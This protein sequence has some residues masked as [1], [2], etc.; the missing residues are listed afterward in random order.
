MDPSKDCDKRM[1]IIINRISDM[2]NTFVSL[3]VHINEVLLY[4][5]SRAGT[6]ENLLHEKI[7]PTMD[8]CAITIAIV[9][10]CPP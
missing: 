1:L 10:E 5:R 9:R 3:A 7:P 4:H 6:P 8:V 2:A